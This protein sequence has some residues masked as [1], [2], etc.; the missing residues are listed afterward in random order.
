MAADGAAPAAA[1]TAARLV[2]AAALALLAG[3]ELWCAWALWFS[4]SGWA[5]GDAGWL[6]VRA[7]ALLAAAG[8]SAFAPRPLPAAAVPALMFGG[9]VFEIARD[10]VFTAGVRGPLL[11][12][13]VVAVRRAARQPAMPL[14]L[15]GWWAGPTW[16]LSLLAVAHLAR[17][18]LL[19]AAVAAPS[20]A[21]AAAAATIGWLPALALRRA[22]GSASAAGFTMGL[23]GALALGAWTGWLRDWLMEGALLGVWWP[24]LWT[25]VAGLNVRAWR[26]HAAAHARSA[27]FAAASGAML[28]WGLGLPAAAGPLTWTYTPDRALGVYPFAGSTPQPHA[29]DGEPPAIATILPDGTRDCASAPG[30]PVVAFVGDSFTFGQGLPD[31]ATLCRAFAD[32]PSLAGWHRVNLGQPGGNMAAS[33][34]TAAFAIEAHHARVVVFGLLPGDDGRAIELN[35]LR[36]FTRT[37]LMLAAG[38]LL[39]VQ[40]FS[41]VAMLSHE[42]WPTEGYQRA[43]TLRGVDALKDLAARHR[44]PIVLDVNAP[45]SAWDTALMRDLSDTQSPWLIVGPID[46]LATDPDHPERPTTFPRDG[47]PTAWGNTVKARRL[48]PAVAAA[49]ATAPPPGP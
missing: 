15:P 43:V 37:P 46:A 9:W 36:R 17:E 13:A 49:V 4:L 7:A 35:A 29:V 33:I 42:L 47:H 44:V 48:S 23:V 30:G 8:V 18:P 5:A 24:L 28:V 40:P 11:L 32:A 16:A 19:A 22:P 45:P 25:G 12:L 27:S 10:S 26:D 6:C 1:P 21:T 38:P 39:G 31:D 20:A 3:W 34:Q 41:E 14:Q 2:A